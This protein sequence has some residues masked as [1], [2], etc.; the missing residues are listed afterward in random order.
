MFVRKSTYDAVVVER[1]AARN[2]TTMYHKLYRDL[3]IKWNHLVEQVNQA[4][5]E[6]ALKSRTQQSEQFSQDDIKRLIQLCH[7][8]KHDGKQSAVEMTKKLN[9][10]RK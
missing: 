10:M 1:D 2:I 8:D 5:G 9:L 4:G 6:R 3:L 7:P